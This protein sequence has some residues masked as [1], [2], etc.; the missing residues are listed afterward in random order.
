MDPHLSPRWTLAAPALLLAACSTVSTLVGD[1]TGSTEK[2][3]EEVKIAE[4]QVGVMRYADDYVARVLQS[5]RQIQATTPEARLA[6]IDWQLGQATAAYEIATGANP[7]LNALDMVALAALTRTSLQ[8]YFVP[9]VFGESGRPLLAT[10]DALEPEAWDGVS[11]VLKPSAEARLRAAIAK[12]QAAN[13][14][15]H[16]VAAIRLVNVLGSAKTGG[17][18]GLGTPTSVLAA[19]GLD[20]LGKLDPAVEEVERTRILAERALYYAKRWPMLLDLQAQKL[21]LQL[22]QQPESQRVL[23]DAERISR[24]AETFARLAEGVPALVDREREAA[25][26]QF[27]DAV[28]SQEGKARALLAEMKETLDAGTAAATSTNGA[29]RSLDSLVATLSQPPPPGSPPSRPFDVSDYTRALAELARA[30]NDLHSLMESIGR[31]APRVEALVERTS[32]GVSERG[33]ALVDYA[34]RRALV[35]VAVFLAGILAV[36]V[37]Y[38]FAAVRIGAR[39]HPASE[40]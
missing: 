39:R 24:S 7:L 30:A 9:K 13:P 5:A 15:V 20:P 32:Q 8:D 28:A 29:L 23:G 17:T 16:D 35:L 18:G 2:K 36:A 21:A 26:R 1:V 14:D 27:L 38:R 12:W 31:D 4:V 3:E 40:E 19:F 34:F 10:C 11:K 22:S 6:L 25:I 33:R 37:G